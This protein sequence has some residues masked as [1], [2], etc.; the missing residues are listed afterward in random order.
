ML[1]SSILGLAILVGACG[2]PGVGSSSNAGLGPSETSE[3]DSGADP[4][5]LSGDARDAGLVADGGAAAVEAIC[6]KWEDL[7]R[8]PPAAASGFFAPL[9]R[10]LALFGGGTLSSEY[11]SPTFEATATYYLRRAGAGWQIDAGPSLPYTN[12]GVPIALPDGD[13]VLT[14][15]FFESLAGPGDAQ[16]GG[17][18]FVLR[19]DWASQ[20]WAGLPPMTRGRAGHA[21]A[22]AWDGLLTVFGG[23]NWDGPST[24]STAEVGSPDGGWVEYV[25]PL[26]IPNGSIHGARAHGKQ[27]LTAAWDPDAG[28]LGGWV[29]ITFN[30]VNGKITEGPPLEGAARTGSAYVGTKHLVLTTWAGGPAL[31]V[32]SLKAQT[33]TVVPVPHAPDL[34]GLGWLDDEHVMVVANPPQGQ[35]SLTGDGIRVQEVDLRTGAISPM[36]QPTRNLSLSVLQFP[37]GRTLL[38][39]IDFNAWNRP[40]YGGSSRAQGRVGTSE[41]DLFTGSRIVVGSV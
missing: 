4:M 6:G 35:F 40:V 17:V 11:G 28:S 36:P 33:W 10:D 18:P 27:V 37:D 1:K 34:A 29:A 14:G 38:R 2:S 24:Q 5:Q 20:A 21:A 39:E 30:P 7:G 25:Y 31:A 13:V 22:A 3:R 9:S 41:S 8:L 16:V 19:L 15:G 23:D 26:Q 32:Y 12:N